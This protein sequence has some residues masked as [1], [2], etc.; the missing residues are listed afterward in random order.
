[1]PDNPLSHLSKLNESTDI[2][3]D[4]RTLSS[5]EFVHL[6]EIAEHSPQVV[7]GLVRADRAMLYLVAVGTGLRASEIGSLTTASLTLDGKLPNVVVDAA[8]SKR[9]RR[10]EQ[11]LPA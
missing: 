2:R 11:P 6:I 3:R 1:M 10:D 5:T 8:Y 4:R 9:R 7:R